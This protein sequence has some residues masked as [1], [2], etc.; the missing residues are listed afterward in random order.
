MFPIFF[1][2]N[3]QV[4]KSYGNN[5]VKVQLKLNNPIEVDCDGNSTCFFRG[6]NYLPSKLAEAVKELSDDLKK[7]GRLEDE[8]MEELE[9]EYD[10]YD[11]YGDMDGII[12][13]N[14][15]DSYGDVFAGDIVAN[16]Y[17]VFDKNQI[18]IIK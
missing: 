11:S 12:M 2:D 18:K 8:Y 13:K 16:N 7:Y 17:V 10:W 9:R 1:T 14:I 6:K 5:I 3:I 4:A 15:K